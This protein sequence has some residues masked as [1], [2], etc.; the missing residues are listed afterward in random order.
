[1]LPASAD[2][3]ATTMAAEPRSTVAA[4]LLRTAASARKKMTELPK[5]SQQGAE[6]WDTDGEDDDDH[7]AR[8]I[9]SKK[10]QPSWLDDWK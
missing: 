9:G 1:L 6:E 5:S 7:D 3:G 10:L 2:Y 4:E 8:T